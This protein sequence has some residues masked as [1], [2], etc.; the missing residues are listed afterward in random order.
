MKLSYSLSH[1]H[2]FLSFYMYEILAL[3]HSV[4][5]K[6]VTIHVQIPVIGLV[7]KYL[8][9]CYLIATI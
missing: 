1:V 9:L 8:K 2:R 7:E 4:L 5:R 6:I 3:H